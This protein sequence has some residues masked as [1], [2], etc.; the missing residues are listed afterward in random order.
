MKTQKFELLKEIKADFQ[1]FDIDS[2]CSSMLILNPKG[3]DIEYHLIEWEWDTTKIE[4]E[5]QNINLDFENI[6]EED[7][8]DDIPKLKINDGKNEKRNQTS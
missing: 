5:L 2:L 7:L 8:E 1:Y 3:R 4:E 6:K